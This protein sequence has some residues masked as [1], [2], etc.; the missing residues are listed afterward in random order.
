MTASAPDFSR[1]QKVARLPRHRRAEMLDGL[2]PDDL[3][4]NWSFWGRPSQ[5]ID[6]DTAYLILFLAGRG[7]VAPWT[8]V[9]DPDSDQHIRVD[10]FGRRRVQTLNGPREQYLEPFVKGVDHQYTVTFE[11]GS[12]ITATPNH[13]FLSPQGWLRLADVRVGQLLAASARV[14]TPRSSDDLSEFRADA[15][16][17]MSRAPDFQ[18][19]C[20]TCHRS[21]GQRPLLRPALVLAASPSRDGERVRTLTWSEQGGQVTSPRCSPACRRT[22]LPPRTHSGLGEL[23]P[24]AEESPASSSRRVLPRLTRPWLRRFLDTTSFRLPGREARPRA[25]A[26][27]GARPRSSVATPQTSLHPLRCQPRGRMRTP[28][29]A[30]GR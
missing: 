3:A 24:S 8:R 15:Q 12:S 14:P 20:P 9:Y 18:D 7:C 23:S 27:R 11:D 26:V 2:D 5:I 30:D 10:E 29:D 19:G 4:Y 1:A 6:S 21:G 28:P 16:R 25:R 13:R 22:A 17:S